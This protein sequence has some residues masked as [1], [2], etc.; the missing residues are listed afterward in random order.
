MVFGCDRAGGA[1]TSCPAS[2]IL[3]HASTPLIHR[4]SRMRRRARTDL[5]GGR[6]VMVVPTATVI[7][8]TVADLVLRRSTT[9]FSQ[10]RSIEAATDFYS[11]TVG[12]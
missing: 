12:Q 10:R 3:T 9:S 1:G 11:A 8:P 4:K 5:C 2:P 7:P 6:S